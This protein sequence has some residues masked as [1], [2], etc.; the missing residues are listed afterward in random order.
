MEGLQN[1]NLNGSSLK[2]LN[3]DFLLNLPISQI[4][5]PTISTITMIADQNPALKIS[6]MASQLARVRLKK[7]SNDSIDVLSF[8]MFVLMG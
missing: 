5:I 7:T 3:Y 4:I 8:I 2:Y 6:P 1:V